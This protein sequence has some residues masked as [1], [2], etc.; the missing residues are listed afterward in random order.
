MWDSVVV[1]HSQGL[2]WLC[3]VAQLGM[4]RCVWAVDVSGVWM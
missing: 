1:A 3:Q 4:G 2:G